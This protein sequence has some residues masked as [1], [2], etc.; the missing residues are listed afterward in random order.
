MIS[1]ELDSIY[2]ETL[3]F[4]EFSNDFA[5]LQCFHSYMFFEV[6]DVQQLD[7][8]IHSNRS[9][10][11][12]N[13]NTSN[14]GSFEAYII[15]TVDGLIKLVGEFVS[16]EKRNSK[17]IFSGSIFTTIDAMKIA[18]FSLEKVISFN[19]IIRSNFNL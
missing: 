16:Q 7:R 11:P 10:D 5:E 18:E 8:P 3:K 4:G 12:G 6:I 17:Q 13:S 9:V 2:I 1:S 14:I 19:V 15:T